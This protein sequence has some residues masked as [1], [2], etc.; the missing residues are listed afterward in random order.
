MAVLLITKISHPLKKLSYYY[1]ESGF[2]A[3]YERVTIYNLKPLI[4]LPI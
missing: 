3:R 1:P 2:E 4:V